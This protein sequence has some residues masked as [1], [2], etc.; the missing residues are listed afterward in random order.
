MYY[1][2]IVGAKWLILTSRDATSMCNSKLSNSHE[3]RNVF[4]C[5]IFIPDFL[6]IY[7]NTNN[8][9]YPDTQ[10]LHHTIF[11]IQTRLPISDFPIEPLP[12]DG[13]CAHR[14]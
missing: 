8:I 4:W 6:H 9:Q 5:K 3:T 12:H 1:V 11:Q 7:R 14:S 13:M 10:R 2:A